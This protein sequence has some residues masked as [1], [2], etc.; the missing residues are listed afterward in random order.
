MSF[1]KNIGSAISSASEKSDLD[2][3]NSKLLSECDSEM[4]TFIRDKES[5]TLVEA[6]TFERDLFERLNSE[7]DKKASKAVG[8]PVPATW[9]AGG[10][11]NLE[12]RKRI[13]NRSLDAKKGHIFSSINKGLD[14]MKAHFGVVLRNAEQLMTAFSVSTHEL[15]PLKAIDL[16]DMIEKNVAEIKESM[17]AAFP[18]GYPKLV[19]YASL[20]PA[21]IETF[22]VFNQ[23]QPTM[24]KELVNANAQ[25]ISEACVNY[26]KEFRLKMLEKMQMQ[27]HAIAFEA[28]V[29]SEQ[30]SC[31]FLN[32]ESTLLFSQDLKA[33]A[34]DIENS[35]ILSITSQKEE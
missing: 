7:Y 26:R 6:E 11:D 25:A 18:G 14:D 13:L 33:V 12:I 1:F 27:I 24:A 22:A 31:S 17:N 28:V 34:L 3:I 29:E 35:V 32:E 19:E 2:A 23:R 4:K 5:I 10:Q 8:R 21:D 9:N 20:T 15:M 16:H 30:F